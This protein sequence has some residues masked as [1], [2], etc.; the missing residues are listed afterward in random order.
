[1]SGELVVTSLAALSYLL[2]PALV[3]FQELHPDLRVRFMTGE[4]LFRLEYGEAHV[5]IRAGVMPD[6]PD[7]VVQPFMH[8]R[9]RL[10]ASK[11]SRAVQQVVAQQ[12]ECQAVYLCCDGQ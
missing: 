8:L 11:Q 9:M 12:G 10:M 2:T 5:A 6:Q 4:R 3:S 7:N 1:M